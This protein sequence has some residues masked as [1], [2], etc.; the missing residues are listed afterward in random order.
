MGD[1]ATDTTHI[2]NSP[3]LYNLLGGTFSLKYG[4]FDVPYWG[5]VGSAAREQGLITLE[6][7]QPD[8]LYIIAP[9][10]AL[11]MLEAGIQMGA[12]AVRMGVWFMLATGHEYDTKI[13]AL[14]DTVPGFKDR[15]IADKFSSLPAEDVSWMLGITAPGFDGIAELRKGTIPEESTFLVVTVQDPKIISTP[16]GIYR[17]RHVLPSE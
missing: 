4:E 16:A 17:P 5:C 6:E 12:M 11:W 13:D 2:L 1:E 10:T 3:E 8:K 14:I 15:M 7:G 9:E